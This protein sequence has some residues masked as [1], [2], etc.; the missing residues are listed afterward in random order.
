MKS[1]RD[2]IGKKFGKY[3]GI[4]PTSDRTLTCYRRLSRNFG[5]D[6]NKDRVKTK[7]VY[8]FIKDNYAGVINIFIQYNKEINVFEVSCYGSLVSKNPTQTHVIDTFNTPFEFVAING[9]FILKN[10]KML[11]SLV[12][13]PEYVGGNFDISNC[14]KLTSFDGCPKTV[15]G[16]FIC[17]KIN[18]DITEEYIRSLCDVKGNIYIK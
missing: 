1:L 16:D 5:N 7:Q 3:Q 17:S 9:D 4:T 15:T 12:G 11:I 10:R 14:I 8:D 13:C 18:D 2:Y 6:T